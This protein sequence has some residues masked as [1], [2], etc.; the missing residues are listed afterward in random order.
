MH[1]LQLWPSS[2]WLVPMPLFLYLPL[3]LLQ[4]RPL[5]LIAHDMGAVAAALRQMSQA[6]HVGKVVVRHPPAQAQEAMAGSWLV[7]GGVGEL[8]PTL[9]CLIADL[10]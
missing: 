5:P 9:H 2:T 7:T 3:P 10:L 6:R 4:L 1:E 8:A